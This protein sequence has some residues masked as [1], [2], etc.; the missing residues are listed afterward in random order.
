[1]GKDQ[2]FLTKSR[3]LSATECPAKLYFSK[4]SSYGNNKLENPFLE[5]LAEGGF[6]VGAL[7]KHMIPGGIEISSLDPE[8]ALAETRHHLAKNDVILYEAAFSYGDFFVRVDILRKRGNF[9]EIIEVKAKSVDLT[10]ESPFLTRGRKVPPTLKSEWLPYFRDAAFQKHVVELAS[11]GSHVET[12]LMLVDKNA[13]CTTD[14]LNQK[15]LLAR[16]SNGRTR[17]RVSPSLTEEGLCRNI[18][19]R[20]QVDDYLSYVHGACGGAEVGRP[21]DFAAEA[22]FF[23]NVLHSPEPIQTDISQ[24]PCKKCEFRIPPAWEERGL[25]NGFEECWKSYFR[26]AGIP[27]SAQRIR[28]PKVIDIWNFTGAKELMGRSKFFLDELVPGDI[29]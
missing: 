16:D 5:S 10:E 7:A 4:N 26:E 22:Q 14:G 21:R 17:V 18:L 24:A 19:V 3:Y 29:E 28:S 6:Q 9:L 15:F 12:S 20:V 27:L 13:T 23:A 1:M 8:E 25:R 2:R 11:S